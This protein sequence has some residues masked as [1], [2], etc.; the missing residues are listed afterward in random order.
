MAPEVVEHIF[1]P[2]FTTKA[3]GAG[4]GL[5]LA[6]VHGIVHQHKG[7]VEVHSEQGKGTTFEVYLPVV[8]QV[9]ALSSAPEASGRVTAGRPPCEGPITGGRETILLAEDDA[10]VR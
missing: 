4:T 6:T 2:F 1:E 8:E 5:G 10:A 9:A 3:P 7:W